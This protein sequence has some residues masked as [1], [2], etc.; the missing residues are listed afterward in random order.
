M[1][2]Q[3]VY[4]RAVELYKQNKKG[5]LELIKELAVTK[6]AWNCSE[7]RLCD[8]AIFCLE[9]LSKRYKMGVIANQGVGLRERLL[10]FGILKFFD[11]IVSSAEEGVS[12]PDVRIFEIALKRSGCQPYQA[13]MIGDR[14]DND[15]L[16]AKLVGM[17]T[18]WIKQGFGRLWNITTPQEEPDAQANYL[19]DILHIL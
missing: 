4:D 16:P 8:D 10:Q 12:K 5:D 11:L 19:S 6:P 15:I 14:I 2:Y 13:V 17:N 9:S 1:A 7:E 3:D 18:L